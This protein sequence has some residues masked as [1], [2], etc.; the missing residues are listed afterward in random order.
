MLISSKEKLQQLSQLVG[1][2][3]FRQGLTLA[4]S[5]LRDLGSSFR[6][7]NFYKAECLA[8]LG[9]PEEVIPRPIVVAHRLLTCFICNPLT[10][11][12]M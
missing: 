7:V 4:D 9:R 11:I 2:K 8:E 6:D 3:S 12:E 1:S 10:H 5:L